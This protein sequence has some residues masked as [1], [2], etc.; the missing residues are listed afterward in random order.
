MLE[1]TRVR[2]VVTSILYPDDGSVRWI[3]VS[4]QP[5]VGFLFGRERENGS[6]RRGVEA[7]E[8]LLELI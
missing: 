4:Q 7:R 6:Q 5:C 3:G 2:D 8:K 1:R